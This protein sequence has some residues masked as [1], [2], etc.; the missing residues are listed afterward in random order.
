[1]SKLKPKFQLFEV[2]DLAPGVIAVELPNGLIGLNRESLP[3]ISD[4]IHNKKTGRLD[5]EKSIRAITAF[6][7]AQNQAYSV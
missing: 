1:M 6:Y 4:L 5:T 7:L 2:M 3:V